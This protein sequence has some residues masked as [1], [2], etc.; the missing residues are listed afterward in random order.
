VY[1]LVVHRLSLHHVEVMFEDCF[2]LRVVPAE[3]Q[4][5]K[6]LMARRY[7]ETLK[8]IMARI[9]GGGLVHVDETEVN[10]HDGKG[11]V[12]VLASMEDVVFLYRP[13]RETVFLRE[14]LKG[15]K[16]VL[17]SDFYPGYESLPCEQQT[18]LVHL[19][20][21]MNADLMGSPYDEEFKALA[22]E[23]G[24]L[25]R[26]IVGTIDKYGL[27]KRHLHKHKAEVARFFRDLSTCV[28][29]SELA[30]GY[31]K[32]LTKNEGRLFTFL[33]HNNVPWNN[34]AAEHAVKAFAAYRELYDGWMSEEGLSDHLVLLSVQ[35]TCKYRGVSFLKFLLSREE[36]VGAFCERRRR[37]TEPPAI[38]VYPDGF[39][40]THRKMKEGPAVECKTPSGPA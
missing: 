2:G 25:L 27:K 31:Q 34:N 12:W 20:R 18:C 35:Q 6:A 1:Q 11:Y 19:I 38:E 29:R 15:F 26:S 13:N 17:V 8:G 3:V 9:V 24:K 16:G 28:Y 37:K 10:L 33:D 4:M 40:R 22:M 36:D 23:F 32:R 39:S 5:M 21:D 14:L 7:R 30:E